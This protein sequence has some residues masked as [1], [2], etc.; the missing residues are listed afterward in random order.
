M[1]CGASELAQPVKILAVANGQVVQVTEISAFWSVIGNT[2]LGNKSCLPN[3]WEERR[4]NIE[5]G[6]FELA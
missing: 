1:L 2:C 5:K 3:H 4:Y 6:P